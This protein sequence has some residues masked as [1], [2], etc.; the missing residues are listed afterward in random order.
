MRDAATPRRASERHTASRV[1][2]EGASTGRRMG[3]STSAASR[4]RQPAHGPAKKPGILAQLVPIAGEA[5]DFPSAETRLPLA[6]GHV[7]IEVRVVHRGAE[8][9]SWYRRGNAIRRRAADQDGGHQRLHPA[10]P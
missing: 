8:A 2:T 3:P 7:T 10:Q 9:Q 6:E 4:T 5:Q 1:V